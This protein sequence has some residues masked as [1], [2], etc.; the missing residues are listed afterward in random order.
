MLTALGQLFL[1]LCR[2]FQLYCLVVKSNFVEEYFSPYNV[3]THHCIMSLSP[4]TVLVITSLDVCC[5][6]LYNGFHIHLLEV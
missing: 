6:T 3:I 5:C 4:F 1:I 2:L